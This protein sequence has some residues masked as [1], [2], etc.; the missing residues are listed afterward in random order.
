MVPVFFIEGKVQPCIECSSFIQSRY[1]EA[2]VVNDGL[3]FLVQYTFAFSLVVTPRGKT[4]CGRMVVIIA[5]HF[6]YEG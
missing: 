6:D 3:I 4:F 1:E 2:K 5:C